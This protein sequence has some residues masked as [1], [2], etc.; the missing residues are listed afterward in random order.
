LGLVLAKKTEYSQVWK[1]EIGIFGETG[2]VL[3][4]WSLASGSFCEIRA[5][6]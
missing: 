4:D 2:P 6:G 5:V 1:R 3:F